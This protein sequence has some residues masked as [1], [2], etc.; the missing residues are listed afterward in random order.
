MRYFIVTYA[1]QANGKYNELVKL[2]DRI[3]KRDESMATV[4]LDYKTRK[5]V[6]CRL[7]SDIERN[8]NNISDF[9]KLH[10][11]KAIDAL[12]AKF[13]ALEELKDELLGQTKVDI[14]EAAQAHPEVIQDEI[15]K[16]TI[17]NL[18]KYAE[19]HPKTEIIDDTK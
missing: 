14:G 12:E 16:E 6:K 5:V 11:D 7:A 2:D 19:E 10:Y 8:F 15:D 3:R 13:K 9:Y 17:D 18:K 1:Q 4:I